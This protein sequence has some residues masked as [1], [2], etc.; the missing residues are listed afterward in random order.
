MLRVLVFCLATL[1]GVPAFAQSATTLRGTVEAVAPDGASF[2]AHARSGEPATVRLKTDTRFVA[3]IAADLKDVKEGAYIGVAAV[4]DGDDGLKALE[5]HIFPE[6]MRG[7]G[8]GFRPFDLAPRSS[9]TNG[10]VTAHV[11]AVA[12]P[13]VTVSYKGGSQT[14]R[15]DSTTAIVAFAPADKA[16]LKPG[17]AIIARGAKSAD[18]V[19]D[20]TS[21][22]IGRNGLTPPM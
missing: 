8:E 10:S 16:E 4:P 12:G 7:V 18:G 20:A 19:I 6:S 13:Q 17:V 11:D 15:I 21:V 1:I 3:V 14:I 9:M 22:V 5:V 2:T